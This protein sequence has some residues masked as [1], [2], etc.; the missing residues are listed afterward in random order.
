M[1]SHNSFSLIYISSLVP[2]KEKNMKNYEKWSFKCHFR[3][4]LFS[5]SPPSKCWP[6]CVVWKI[7]AQTFHYDLYFAVLC[8]WWYF[9]NIYMEFV[10]HDDNPEKLPT[11]SVLF[12]ALITLAPNQSNILKKVPLDH[13]NFLMKFVQ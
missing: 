13:H 2:L 8:R 10:V 6:F 12:D 7:H 3:N 1:S 4:F 11:R 9:I 5:I